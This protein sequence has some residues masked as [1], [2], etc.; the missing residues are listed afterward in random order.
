M[1]WSGRAMKPSA[2]AA[3]FTMIFRRTMVPSQPALRETARDNRVPT[4]TT[5]TIATESHVAV[6]AAPAGV[7][8][9]HEAVDGAADCLC[10]AC[11]SAAA[12]VQSG[13]AA[14][15]GDAD[16]RVGGKRAGEDEAA[17]RNMNPRR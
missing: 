15:A 7:T 16:D 2:L 12:R 1:S 11:G 14:F 6:K 17:A 3:M 10:V 5:R 8:R 13:V 9:A 4:V